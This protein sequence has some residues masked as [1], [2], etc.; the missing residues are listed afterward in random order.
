MLCTAHCHISLSSWAHVPPKNLQTWHAGQ[1][2][3]YVSPVMSD[4]YIA[5]KTV[6]HFVSPEDHVTNLVTH[7]PW[8]TTCHP[9]T[10]EAGT[11]VGQ[12]VSEVA[13]AQTVA[14]YAHNSG[15]ATFLL[16]GCQSTLFTR[17]SLNGRLH[18]AGAAF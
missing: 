16:R 15:T 14:N 18:A 1:Y 7:F 2:A 12:A 6:H 9:T 13:A 10:A 11:A 17:L 8:L 3:W 4:K 5:V